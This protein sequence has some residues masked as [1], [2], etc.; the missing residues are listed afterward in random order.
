LSSSSNV[1]G[2]KR[3]SIRLARSQL[4]GF[5]LALLAVFAAAELGRRS[6]SARF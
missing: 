1:P 2:S 4:P 5:M 3:S 6:R